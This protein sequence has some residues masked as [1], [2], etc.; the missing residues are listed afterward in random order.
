MYKKTLNFLALTFIFFIFTTNPLNAD[1]SKTTDAIMAAENFL[2]LV[3]TSQYAQSW[4]AASSFFKNQVPKETWVKQISSIRPA[5]GKLTNREIISAQYT[6]EPPGAPD[7]QYVI[8]QYDTSFENKRKALE[9]ITPML[10][11]DG[12]WRVSGY[13][14]K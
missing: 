6:K 12:K 8:I 11:K 10:D 2:L 7:G 4:D 5:F 1:D 3:D 9:T 13:Y 14:I